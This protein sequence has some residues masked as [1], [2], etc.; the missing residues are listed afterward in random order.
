M[1]VLTFPI[2]PMGKCLADMPDSTL[3]V[4]LG[5]ILVLPGMGTCQPCLKILIAPMGNLLTCLLRLTLAQLRTLRS[6]T[7]CSTCRRDLEKFPSPRPIALMGTLLT[8]LP[9]LS[10]AQLRPTLRSTTVLCTCRRDLEKFHR[11]HGKVADVL[12]PAHACAVLSLLWRTCGRDLKFP[13]APMGKLLTC[14]P[15]LTLARLRTLWSIT[16]SS[17]CRRDLEK[18]PSPRWEH[19]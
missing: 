12:A 1:C 17:T 10:L 14:L 2:A 8:G 4:R 11:P 13:N 3:V 9:R 5:S 18:F 16:E 15:R 19:C 6:T 7:E